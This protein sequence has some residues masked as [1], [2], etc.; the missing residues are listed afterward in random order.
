MSRGEQ[1]KGN[2]C[3]VDLF[4]SASRVDDIMLSL[5]FEWSLSRR[6]KNGGKR[7]EDSR[8]IGGQSYEKRSPLRNTYYLLYRDWDRNRHPRHVSVIGNLPSG[9]LF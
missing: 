3:A 1:S 7:R 5:R 9:R 6:L 8:T 4:I 2:H